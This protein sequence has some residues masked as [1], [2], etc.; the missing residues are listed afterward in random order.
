MTPF[1]RFHS[2]CLKM[3]YYGFKHMYMKAANILYQFIVL[4]YFVLI[5]AN[6]IKLAC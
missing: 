4:T 1:Y 2:M 3:C 5:I 6:A